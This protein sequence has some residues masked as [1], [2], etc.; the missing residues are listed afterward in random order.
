[1]GKD[2]PDLDATAQK[3]SP[4]ADMTV[5]ER[6]PEDQFMLIACDGIYDVLTNANAAAFITNQLKAGYKAEEVVERLL[7]YCLHLDSKDNMSAILVLFENAP[8]PEEGFVAPEQFPDPA[9]TF[10]SSGN[11]DNGVAQPSPDN[12]LQLLSS[13]M[14]NQGGVNVVRADDNG[15]SGAAAA[16][17]ADKQ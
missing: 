3:I 9:E 8:K 17:T 15:D 7:D 2:M 16:D 5:I 6:N 4:E 10:A 1:M 14:S 12:I 13:M 11:G